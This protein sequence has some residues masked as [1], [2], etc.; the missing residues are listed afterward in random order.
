[1]N[2]DDEVP[3]WQER[4][5]ATVMYAGEQQPNA[6]LIV[7]LFGAGPGQVLLQVR[8]LGKVDLSIAEQI[9][10]LR[11]AADTLEDSR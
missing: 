4:V 6:V 9:R 7:E 8:S 3:S 2:E 5:M 1:M 10:T 11:S